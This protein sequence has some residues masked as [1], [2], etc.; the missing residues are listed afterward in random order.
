MFEK[1]QPQFVMNLAAETHV[2]RSIDDPDQFVQTMS[3]NITLLQEA[4]RFCA[5]SHWP[6]GV[7][8]AF[9]MSPP[10]SLWSSA[11]KAG[12]RKT[13]PTRRTRPT[14]QPRRVGSDHLV[15]A[16]GETYE[17]PT[18]ITNCSNNYGRT[19]PEKLVPHMIIRSLAGSR[20]PSWGWAK[21]SRLALCGR[22]R[23]GTH[24]RSGARQH[25]GTYNIGSRNGRTTL[26]MVRRYAPLLDECALRQKDRMK[27][28]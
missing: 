4:V 15:R 16:W 6:P 1:F 5:L 26:E 22:P 23:A 21:R 19:I 18:V 12:L 20:F 17:L 11:A 3:S 10:M 8:F 7:R 2:D 28:Y 13:R 27:T 9:F 14:R 25:W 24:A